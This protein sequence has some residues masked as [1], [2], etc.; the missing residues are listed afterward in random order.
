MKRMIAAIAV[1]LC[2][3][4]QPKSQE[5]TSE[6]A[7]ITDK[8]NVFLGSSGDHGQMSPSASTPFNMM[9]IGP[10]TNPHNHTGYE[11]YAKEFD[12]FTHTHLEGVGCTG[13]GG[14]ILIKPILNDNK[15]T[16]LRKVT[17]HA[18]P[19]FYEVSFENGIDAA[20]SVTHN[21]GIHQYNFNGEKG[22]LFIDL[23]FAL[24]NRFVSEEHEI[25][26]NKISGVIATKTTCHAGTYRF[27][28][29]IQLKNMAEIAQISDH[30]IMAKAED[31]SK[32]VKVLIGFSSVSK[33][34]ASQKIENISYENL[35]KE[36]SAAWEKAL[37]RISVEGEEDRE[38]LFYSLLYR[39]LQSPY[40]VSEEDGTYPA[41]DGTL[42][43]TEGT[44]YSGWAIWDNY[45]EQLPMLSMAYP[46]RYRDIVKSIENLYAFGKKN[47]ATDYEPAPTV[48]T[49]HAMVVLLD[50]YNKGYEVD[51]KRIKDSLIKDAESLDYRAPDKALE[52]SYDNWAMAQ[53]MKIDGDTTLYNKYITK[54][55]D[56]KE[57]W[58]KDFKD[59][60]RN[61]VDRMQ[62]RGLYQGTIWQ[63]R[64]FVPFDLNGLK[65]LA[66]GEDQFLEELDTFFRN[67][68]YNH[69]NQPDLQVPGMYN[70]TKEPWKSQELYRKILLDTMVQAYFNDN[71][72]GIDPYVGRI[73]QNKPKAYLRTMDDDAGTMSS[74]FVMRSLGL[75]PANIGDPVY[76]LTAPIFKEISINYPKGKAFKISVTNYNKDHYYVES[77]TL[78]G[79]PLNRNWLTQQEILEGGELVIKTSD[80]PNKEWGVKEA[81]VSSIRQYL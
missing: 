81:W 66:G 78:N 38:D 26:D 57:Y 21:F 67:H 51:I 41:I 45:R 76:Y 8:V 3:A 35:K 52:S 19:G 23:S 1:A 55:L 12:G 34:Y 54:S 11:H 40:I 80:T 16:E 58:N 17:E 50:A 7:N 77:A 46:D 22:G 73:Y 33:E 32:E 15:E 44:I 30:E 79:K 39:G 56:Y 13:S 69:A 14:N 72:K 5:K 25:K 4:C 75:S 36:A 10:H 62:A 47:W 68:N 48:R 65:Q 28:Y 53:L 2:V 61:D 29:E 49:E 70:A 42:Q 59:I 64:W 20:M 74:W 24:S 63:Y 18:K 31:N 9:S 27:Y 37:S 6:S 60:T 43:K 71:S